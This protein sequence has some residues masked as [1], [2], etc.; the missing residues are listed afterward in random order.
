MGKAKAAGC[1]GGDTGLWL[2]PCSA[3]LVAGEGWAVLLPQL[4][5]LEGGVG[6][7]LQCSHSLS[8]YC[9]SHQG[10]QARYLQLGGWEEGFWPEWV[11]EFGQLG[12]GVVL[13]QS[14]VLSIWH[15]ALLSQGHRRLMVLLTVLLMPDDAKRNCQDFASCFPRN[16]AINDEECCTYCKFRLMLIWQLPSQGSLHASCSCKYFLLHEVA[17]DHQA[18]IQIINFRKDLNFSCF[19]V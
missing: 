2:S 13:L 7:G 19:E 17:I 5:L 16:G 4:L 15:W 8:I 6:T 3:P 14:A 11:L 9:K 12:S 1:N 10:R 18:L